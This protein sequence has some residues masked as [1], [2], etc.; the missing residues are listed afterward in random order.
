MIRAVDLMKTYVLGGD[1]IHALDGVSFEIADGEMVAITGPSG[2]GKSTL[3]HI[4]GC[5]D[6]PDSGQYFLAGEDVSRMSRNRLAEVRNKRIGFIFQTFNLLPKLN[7]LENVELPLLY[8]GRTEAKRQARETLVKLGMGDRTKHEPN[9][10]SGGQRQRVAV[11]RALVTDPAILLADE[12]TG[13]LDSRTGQ[14]ILALFKALNQD[15]RTIIIVT[16]DPAIAQFCPRQIN[17]RDGKIVQSIASPAPA[18][19]PVLPPATTA[20]VGRDS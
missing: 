16:H 1:T 2:S 20:P 14:E 12:P 17:L 10:L 7:A 13:N 15:G 3:M 8:A 6:R 11:A 5:L 4:L 9:Q 19:V 18:A